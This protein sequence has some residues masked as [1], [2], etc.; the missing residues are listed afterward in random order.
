MTDELEVREE[1][2][3]GVRDALAGLNKVPAA[4]LSGDQHDQL[5]GALEDVEALEGSLSNEVEQLRERDDDG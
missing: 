1:G 4:A 3:S 5:L 2:L